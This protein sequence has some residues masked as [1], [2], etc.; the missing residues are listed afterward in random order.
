M[1]IGMV[2]L[3]GFVGV[4]IGML[5]VWSWMSIKVAGLRASLEAKN[6]ELED[7]KARREDD[8]R[9]NALQMAECRRA[10]DASV[11]A[12]LEKVTNVTYES[13]KQREKELAEANGQQVTAL[14]EPMRQQLEA[15]RKTTEAAT[16][17]QGEI[18]LKMEGF[19]KGMRDTSLSFGLQAKSF[20]DALTGA[21]K[22]QGNWGETILGQ[23]LE[24]CGLR[25]GTHYVAQTGTGEGIPDYQVFDPCTRKI[26][27][28]DSKMSWTKYEQAYK[29]QPGAERT[30]ALKE[31]VASVK[32]HIDELEK[33]DY[34]SRQKPP[35]DGYSFIPLTAMFVPCDAALAVALEEEPGLVDYAFK[36]NV[37]L[38]SPLTLFGFLQL[39]SRGWAKYDSDRNANE[40]VEQ[41]KL[42]VTYVDRLFRELENMGNSLKSADEAYQKVFKLAVAE[43]SGQCIKGPALEVLKLGGKPRRVLKSKTLSGTAVA[44]PVVTEATD[45]SLER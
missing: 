40:I 33:A 39:V 22:K 9:T 11:N 4:V 13:L 16:K 17:C 25:E 8:R 5:A 10:N 37:A 43:P 45:E 23:V 18:G 15:M 31:H 35:R 2:V 3:V 6:G 29:M 38:V 44:E 21:N 1:N 36:K 41:A 7:E 32:R 26:L 24:N 19:C 42:M 20:T 14:M 27:I 34:P 28:V 12:M 30:Q